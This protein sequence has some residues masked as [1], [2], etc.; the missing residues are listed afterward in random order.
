M[1]IWYGNI[2]EETEWFLKRQTGEWTWVSLALLFGHFVLPFLALVSRVPKRRPRLLAVAGAWVLL[3]HW[4]DLY[5]LA[6]PEFS[7]GVAAFGLI[8]VLC[9]V[10]LGG[11]FL[12][13]LTLNLRRHSLVPEGDPRLAESMAFENA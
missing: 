3:M 4:V 7:P 9:F 5:W 11:L 13:G 1:L 10:G 8:D 2:P 6:M 12:G